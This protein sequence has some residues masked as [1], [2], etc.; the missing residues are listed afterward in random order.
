MQRINLPH[1]KRLIIGLIIIGLI[2]VSCFMTWACEIEMKTNI[3]SLRDD[4]DKEKKI[5]ETRRFVYD[6][7]LKGQDRY[8]NHATPLPVTLVA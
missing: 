8:T 6:T 5:L 2:R 4:D 3:V 1:R 7:S